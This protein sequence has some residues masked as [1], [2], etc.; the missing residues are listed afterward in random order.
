M[1]C[2]KGGLR[3]VGVTVQKSDFVGAD[4]LRVI[5]GSKVRRSSGCSGV[6]GQT[7]LGLTFFRWFRGL[8]G[9]RSDS[10]GADVLQVVEF[11]LQLSYPDVFRG[12]LVLQPPQLLLLFEEHLE[13]LH[14]EDM[15]SQV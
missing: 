10:V 11:Q 3:A 15:V 5:E 9:Q 1:T 13:H 14:T 12:Q 6:K 2:P 7:L 8:R 4:V